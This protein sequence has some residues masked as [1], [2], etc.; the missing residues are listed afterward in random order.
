MVM[1]QRFTETLIYPSESDVLRFPPPAACSA[2]SHA[3]ASNRRQQKTHL[4]QTVP[5]GGTQIKTERPVLLL[6]LNSL[7]TKSTTCVVSFRLVVSLQ[8]TNKGIG[9]GERKQQLFL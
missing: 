9:A 2:S 8:S 4:D 1:F 3:W 7:N 6:Q 5:I